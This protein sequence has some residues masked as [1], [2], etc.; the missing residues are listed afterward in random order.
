MSATG[1]EVAEG[2]RIVLD[3]AATQPNRAERTAA[4]VEGYPCPKC[5]QM[6]VRRSRVRSTLGLFL[7]FFFVMRYRC[8]GCYRRFWAFTPMMR[9]VND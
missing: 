8:H 7:S 1:F 9:M 2:H 6:R 5:G 4:A 3:L